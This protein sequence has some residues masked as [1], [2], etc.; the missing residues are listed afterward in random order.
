ML[1]LSQYQTH[2]PCLAALKPPTEHLALSKGLLLQLD[3]TRILLSFCEA[4]QSWIQVAGL[5]SNTGPRQRMQN[6]WSQ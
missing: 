3:S 1:I 2:A 5:T 6:S 4:D